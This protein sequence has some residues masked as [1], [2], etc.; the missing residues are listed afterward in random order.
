MGNKDLYSEWFKESQKSIDVLELKSWDDF[1]VMQKDKQ[2]IEL[3][4]C[5]F[6]L[7]FGMVNLKGF[8]L[9]KILND[10][11]GVIL[12]VTDKN[13]S[14][15]NSAWKAKDKADENEN[16]ETD[17]KEDKLEEGEKAT[18]ENEGQGEVNQDLNPTDKDG[19]EGKDSE[20][21]KEDK[22]VPKK[23][24]EPDENEDKQEK[25][26]NEVG[27]LPIEVKVEKVDK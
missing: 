16:T 24:D 4:D 20:Q 9:L 17:S 2:F 21:T 14:L 3:L 26:E 15:Y 6:T 1:A 11:K 25:Q 10:L 19:E 12:N 13:R 23:K 5:D 7:Q 27:P 8:P 18:E 22:N